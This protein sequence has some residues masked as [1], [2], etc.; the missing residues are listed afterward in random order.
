MGPWVDA[1][2]IVSHNNYTFYN[3]YTHPYLSTDKG[4]TVYFE[5]TYTASFSTTPTVTPLYNYNQMMY[6]VDVDDAQLRLPVPV[7]YQPV[8]NADKFGTK[9]SVAPSAPRLAAPF[10]ALDRPAASMVPVGW[11]APSCDPSRR[12][13]SGAGVLDPLFYAAPSASTAP[14][15]SMVGLYEYTHAD[16]RR[17]HSVDA[18]TVPAGF[19]RA[20][21]PLVWVW[22]NPVKP[23]LPV[24]A[25]RGDLLVRAGADRCVAKSASDVTSVTMRATS[26]RK[27]NGGVPTYR[28]TVPASQVNAGQS[29]TAVGDTVVLKLAAGVHKIVLEGSDA[30]GNMSSDNIVVQVK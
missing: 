7:Y 23:V 10:L 21:L 27:G 30:A 24:G 26:V 12:L 4:K 2:K 19:V 13:V 25:Y 29:A 15:R 20:A 28:W 18:T 6:R 11:S 8:H 22:S 16:G 14:L 3:P 5:A 17:M 9:Q 1:R